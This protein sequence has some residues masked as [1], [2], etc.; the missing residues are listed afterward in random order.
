LAEDQP[1]TGHGPRSA[2]KPRLLMSRQPRDAIG[3]LVRQG[4]NFSADNRVTD[5]YTVRSLGAT[6]RPREHCAAIST[7]SEVLFLLFWLTRMTT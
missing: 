7:I 1:Q 6:R 2:V 3:T 5:E 4:R